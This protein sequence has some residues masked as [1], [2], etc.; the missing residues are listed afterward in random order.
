M[1]IVFADTF[2]LIALLNPKDQW[3]RRAIEVQDEIGAIRLI[4]TEAV[5]TEF[6]NYF[7]SYGAEMRQTA[8]KTVRALLNNTDVE[9]LPQT[10]ETF[11]SGLMLYEARRDKGYSQTDCIS[12][13]EMRE[14]GLN[15]TLTHDMHFAQEGFVLLL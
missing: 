4:T 2:Y 10:P 9:V 3:H 8:V 12:M 15:E 7:C 13:H 11:L 1:R 6:L 5:L 14:R